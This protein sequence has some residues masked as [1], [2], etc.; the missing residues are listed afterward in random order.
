MGWRSLGDS[1]PCFRRE[2]AR[3]RRYL[4]A[5]AALAPACPRPR[6]WPAR[7]SV[8]RGRAAP[9]SCWARAVDRR[10]VAPDHDPRFGLGD[11]AELHADVAAVTASLE[12]DELAVA[13]IHL[14]DGRS[15]PPT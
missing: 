2:R 12:A 7:A 4:I 6:V 9:H 15:D 14:R 5:L 10:T 1:N 11:L 8:H 3:L 13:M